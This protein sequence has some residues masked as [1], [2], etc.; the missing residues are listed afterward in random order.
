MAANKNKKEK[1]VNLAIPGELPEDFT[2]TRPE[3][4]TEEEVSARRADGLGN[5]VRE[6]AGKSVPRILADNALTFFNLLNIL[7]GVALASVGAWRNMLF[8]G[9]VISNTVIGTV[10]EIRAHRAIR[11]LKLA[12]RSPVRVIREGEEREVAPEETVKGDLVRLRAGDRVP[13][14]AICVDGI[15]AMN[16]ALL[17]GESD[18]VTKHPGD[19]LM[20][21]SFVSRGAFTVQL[22]RVGES[23]YLSQLTRSAKA[24][25]RPKSQLMLEL[26]RLIR[27]L[28]YA[29]VPIG[30]T[31]FWKQYRLRGNPLADSVTQAAASMIG[32]IPE[33]LMLLTSVAMAV[34]VVRLSRRQTLV[35]ELHGIE[36]L[37]RADVLC[38]DK[39][40][41][42]TTGEMRLTGVLPMDGAADDT[43]ARRALARFLGASD[44]A[45]P[46]LTALAAAVPPDTQQAQ[47]VAS[48][49]FSSQ[50]KLSAV[51]FADGTTLILGAPSFVLEDAYAGSLR[52]QAE[53]LAADGHRV[54]ALCE[55]E[56]AVEGDTL[57]PVSRVLA[58][59]AL[60]DCLRP[61]IEETLGYFAQQGVAVKLIS[62]DDPRTVAS[63]AK[64][65]G[66]AGTEKLLDVSRATEEELRERCEDTVVFGRVTPERKRLLVRLLQERGHSV[67][68]TGDGVN[69]IPAL[70]AADCSIAIAG[71]SDA[72][73][74]T[75]QLTL[76]DADFASL[77]QVVGEGRRVIN[78]I[79][80]SASLFL[81]KTLYSLA[82][83]VALLFLPASY[84]FKPIQLTLV[85][86]VTIGI[87]SFFL[88]LQP[89]TERVRGRFLR[90][91]V[92]QAVPGAAAV[93][94]CAAVAMHLEHIGLPED[95]CST[96]AA[97]SAG[98][99]GLLVLLTHCLPFNR[100]RA[101]LF[102]LMTVLFVGAM[103][104]LPDVFYLVRL[105]G[106]ELAFLAGL[107]AAGAA[108]LFGLRAWMKR[109]QTRE[110]PGT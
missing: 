100:L 69:D 47:P 12:S 70:K 92:R 94:L 83:S 87:P 103:V 42:L 11:R 13:A 58:L 22:E 107:I 19:W 8:L 10:Q 37:A 81:V 46:T 88:A 109:R 66:V 53:A 36:T 76:L 52:Q 105:N 39:T 85:S 97:A 49:P 41:T 48:L 79:T 75:A 28:S 102:A 1:S 98:A 57:P 63:L 26:A 62:G 3:G 96:L 18:D 24:I 67:A 55:A 25:K 89:N 40:G 34:G 93:T 64:R 38:L 56:G 23:S 50:R 17:T 35:Q 31:L 32:M 108:V 4:L 15:G 68:M 20:S 74:Q 65:A 43:A 110:L 84:P 14:D 30:L 21:G 95:I 106:R 60:S 104:L 2:P 59:I 99:V 29:I 80:Q 54:L 45:G 6:T 101:A 78:N 33:G 27:W 82:L 7:I 73:R 44:I 9:V 77:P 5:T 61:H 86:A 71:G 90:N 16:E 72:A 91:V 51:S